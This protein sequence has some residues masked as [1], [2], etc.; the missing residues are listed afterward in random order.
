MI[1]GLHC[2]TKTFPLNCSYCGERIFFFSCDCGSR[3]FFDE[4]GDSWPIHDCR[5]QPAA[6]GQSGAM[7]YTGPSSWGATIGINILGGRQGAYDLLPGLRGGK[8]SIAP[9]I[10]KRV[11]GSG[12]LG[13]ETM[14]IDPLGSSPVE[15][16]GVVR[17]WSQPDLARR[18][19]V[20]RDSIGF[21]QLTRAIGDADPVQITVH[22]DELAD[23]E[24]AIDF[25]SYTFVAPR[26]L[27]GQGIIQNVV[28]YVRL[29]PLE[30]LGLERLWLAEE[31]ERLY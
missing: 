7:P 2:K 8:D 30:S 31:F 21:E 16:T 4:L 6:G 17:E 22:V 19:S 10:T 20:G 18:F 1:H 15:I 26:I 11:L 3:V 12:N 27:A 25:F 14:R 29:V 9:A 24:S 28:I 13:R 5:T 23:D